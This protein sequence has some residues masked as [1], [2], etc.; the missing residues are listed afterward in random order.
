MT[1][2]RYRREEKIQKMFEA[3]ANQVKNHISEKHGE[4]QA[5]LTE[6][7]Q[8]EG[9][10]TETRLTSLQDQVNSQGLKTA[11]KLKRIEDQG[12]NTASGLK[13]VSKQLSYLTDLVEKSAKK[14]YR[15]FKQS[16]IDELDDNSTIANMISLESVLTSESV[17]SPLSVGTNDDELCNQKKRSPSPLKEEETGPPMKKRIKS[18]IGGWKNTISGKKDS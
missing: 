1:Y 7:I 2:H 10:K 5:V 9:S 6:V 16:D 15:P 14:K 11:T 12:D 8:H 13:D 18:L 3:S 4:T 17:H